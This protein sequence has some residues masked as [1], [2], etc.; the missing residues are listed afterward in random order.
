MVTS[1]RP[2]KTRRPAN[3]AAAI[4]ILVASGVGIARMFIERVRER[5]P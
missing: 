1:S 4:K 5:I 3:V 2:P